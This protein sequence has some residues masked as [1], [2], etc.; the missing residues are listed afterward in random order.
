MPTITLNRNVVEKLSGVKLPDAELKERIAMLG[1]DLEELTKTEINVEI[2]PNR[3][4]LLSEQGF[5]RALASFAG[6]KTGLRKYNAKKSSYKMIIDD[7]VKNVR[8]YTA[9]AVVKNLK[10]DEEKIEEIIKIQ[11]KLHVTY[12]R[13]R[14]KVAIG[15]YPLDKITFPITFKADKP[16]KIIFQP[17]EARQPMTAVEI[18]EQHPTGREYGHLLDGLKTYP[19]FIDKNDEILSL[20]PVINSNTTGRIDE[21]TKDVFIE[22]SGFDHHVLSKALNMILTALADI[23]GELYEIE[24]VNKH[25]KKTT[26]MPEL[27]PEEM[28]ISLKY[29]NARLGL[30]LQEKDVKKMF[31]KNGTRI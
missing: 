25:T 24:V 13:N 20:P 3:P 26:I 19:F 17:L 16:E 31:R 14:K 8:P 11:E 22:C 30:Q 10:F 9:C 6:K 12:G 23:G 21:S 29:V 4:D 15:I 2:F 7:S 18:L 28:K 1:T 27:E 5:A